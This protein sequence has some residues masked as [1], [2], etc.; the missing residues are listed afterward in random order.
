MSEKIYIHWVN[1]LKLNEDVKYVKFT[2]LY[3]YHIY[4]I[5]SIPQKSARDPINSTTE[6]LNFHPSLKN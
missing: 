4:C 5:N 6:D 1:E 2:H 3:L